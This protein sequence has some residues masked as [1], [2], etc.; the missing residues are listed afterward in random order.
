MGPPP[1]YEPEVWVREDAPPAPA[2]KRKRDRSIPVDTDRLQAELTRALGAPKAKRAT[3]RVAEA[4]R[5]FAN[6]QLDDARRALA[7]I[8]ADAPG[9]A[10]V[11]E[12]LGLTLYQLG[13]W[14][15]ATKELEAFREITGSDEQNPVLADCYRALGRHSDAEVLWE[16]LR[17]SSP[18]AEIVAEGRIV[19]AGSLADRGRLSDAIRLLE[20]APRGKKARE[21]HLRTAYALADLRERAGD[22]SRSRE[23]FAWIVGVDPDFADAAQRLD[24]LS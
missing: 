11:R 1:P 9:S 16:A 15:A 20:A 19:A 12:L 3:D 8:A 24:S 17:E 2:P 5:A 21:H 23:L 18:S 14:K 4:A 22:V 13:R 6:Q 7:P 10:S